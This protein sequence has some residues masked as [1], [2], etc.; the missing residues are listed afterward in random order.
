VSDAPE[1]EERP[2]EASRPEV[3][4]DL[5]AYVIV[6][7]PQED[8]L[9]SVVP[10][11]AELVGSA[12]IRILDLV[13]VSR[14]DDGAVTVREFEAVESIA[15]LAE[16]E[17]EVGGMLSERD[18]ALAATALRPGTTGIVVVTEDRWAESLS[19]AAQRAGGQIIGGERIP[20]PRVEDALADRSESDQGG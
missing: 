19:A 6:E 18:V 5:V 14:D 8:S 12:S 20:P 11:L 13:V 15:A 17:G 16:V 4:S 3:T 10:A 9:A 2:P 7:V 1:P